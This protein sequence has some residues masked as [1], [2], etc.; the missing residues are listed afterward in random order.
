[1]GSSNYS[2][3]CLDVDLVGKNCTTYKDTTLWTFEYFNKPI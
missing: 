2:G 1:M 3:L